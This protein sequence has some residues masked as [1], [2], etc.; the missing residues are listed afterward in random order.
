MEHSVDSAA[1]G[2]SQGGE[3]GCLEEGASELRS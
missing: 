1:Q 3:G 2:D